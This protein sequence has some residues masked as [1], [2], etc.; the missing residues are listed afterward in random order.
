MIMTMENDLKTT[1]P[2]IHDN[3][4]SI[5]HNF[6]NIHT[7]NQ[8][9]GISQ[10]ETPNQHDDMQPADSPG[11]SSN[12][13]NS[14]D[15]DKKLDDRVKRPMNAFMVW[16][17]GQRRKMAQEN[18]K[19]HNSEISKRLGQEWKLLNET[20][21][22][23][24]IDEAKRLRAIH[25]KEHPDYKYRPRRKT[26]N[27]VKKIGGGPHLGHGQL[28]MTAAAAAAAASFLDPIKGQVYPTMHG[29]WNQ[30]ATSAANYL[31][32]YGSFYGRSTVNSAYDSLNG[33]QNYLNHGN[34]AT[35]NYQLAAAAAQ[36]SH[37]HNTNGYSGNNGS[38]EQLMLKQDVGNSMDGGNI[39]NQQD[40]VNSLLTAG[41]DP[42]IFRGF[43]DHTIMG[44]TKDAAAAMG[45]NYLSGQNDPRLGYSS[46]TP[47]LDSGAMNNIQLQ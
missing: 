4:P 36:Y 25:M 16:S 31:D 45:M 34:N 13:G 44:A 21:K 11:S 3:Y 32:P 39:Q 23:P 2:L 9:N 15:K 27:L 29:S 20:D 18:P 35:N 43:Y 46:L 12:G 38:A 1:T 6:H 33:M 24:F 42:N 14:C 8:G 7:N 37:S 5:Y 28:Q 41:T 19:M 30:P 17:R 10:P 26:K 22:R 40:T 47:C